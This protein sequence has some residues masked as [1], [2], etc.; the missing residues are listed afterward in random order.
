MILGSTGSVGLQAADVAGRS[1]YS[2]TALSANSNSALMEE[3]IR[4]FGPQAAAM[5]DPSAAAD[6]RLRTADLPV[7]VYSGPDGI[8]EMIARDTADVAVNAIIGTAGLMPTLA[9][10]DRGGDLALANKES[11][12]IAGRE[13]M[14]RVRARRVR[15]TPV[16]SEHC[17]IAECLRSGRRSEVAELIITASGGPFRGRRKEELA[18]VTAAEALAHPTWKM[19]ARI[20]VDSA[21]LMNKGFE[22]IEASVLFGIPESGIRVLV[23]PQSIVHSMVRFRDNS[24]IAQLS[25]PDMRH[26]VQYAVEA[27]ARRPAVVPELDLA[28]AGSLTFEEPDCD[29]FVPLRLAREALRAGGAAPAVLHAAN[30]E[31]VDAFLAGKCTFTGIFGVL[32]AVTEALADSAGATSLEDILEFDRAARK[33]AAGLIER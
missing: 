31:A 9:V 7:R 1:G 33:L 28:A 21:T 15:L 6:L 27:P 24:V 11:L 20:T 29:T 23:H 5:A 10:I 2:V 19:G 18:D 3:Q 26:C 13:V 14:E 25:V 12:V 4:R 16:D 30:E 17:A 8:L 32:S 22:I